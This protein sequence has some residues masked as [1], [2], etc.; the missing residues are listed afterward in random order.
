MC[1]HLDEIRLVMDALK[2]YSESVC[3]QSPMGIVMVEVVLPEPMKFCPWC[4]EEI[5]YET[6]DGL[7]GVERADFQQ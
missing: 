3:M 2:L 6:S 4:M 5:S 1:S 7:Q